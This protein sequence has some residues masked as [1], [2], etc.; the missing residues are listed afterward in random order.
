[1]DNP[2]A[3]ILIFGSGKI[4]CTGTKLEEISAAIDKITDKF[5]SV[6]M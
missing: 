5:S 3:V 4:V 6:G 2:T 1:M